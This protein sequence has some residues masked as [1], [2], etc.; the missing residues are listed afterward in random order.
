MRAIKK[1]YSKGYKFLLTVGKRRENDDKE[2]PIATKWAQCKD[3]G[4]RWG[5]MTS[6]G[7]ESLNHVFKVVRCLPVVA[8]VEGTWYKCV[9]WFDERRI[10][11]NETVNR[12]FHW[13]RNV[14]QKLIKRG[15]KARLHRVNPY[16]S[17]LGEFEVTHQGETLP[18]D[19]WEDNKYHVKL[20]NEG[21]SCG[22]LKPDLTGI[23][24]SHVLA[25]IRV[26]KFS[27]PMFVSNFYSVANLV[28]TWKGR[29][30]PYPNQREWSLYEGPIMIPK[31]TWIRRGRRRH[32]RLSM[33]M[34]EMEGRRRKR[35]GRPLKKRPDGG[36]NF[37]LC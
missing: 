9:N 24:C 32:I 7:S 37:Q 21:S 27:L 36:K 5:I 3:G 2:K 35:R 17:Q 11:S 26:R 1:E 31:R 22:C 15:D 8:I 30:Y 28:N 33:V 19:K 10:Q 16:K 6:N 13:S 4:Y 12:G 18:N 25:V 23:P 34:D 29:F 14:T 20:H